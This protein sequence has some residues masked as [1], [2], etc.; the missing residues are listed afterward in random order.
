MEIPVP[1]KQ[2]SFFVDL[3]KCVGCK[4]CVVA[5]K[6][7]NNTPWRDTWRK[8]DEIKEGSYPD[9]KATFVSLSCNHC[10]QP[11]CLKSCP[12]DAKIKRKE[13]GIVLIDQEKCIGCKRC[14]AA[15]PYGAPQFNENSQKVEKCTFCFH[16]LEAGLEP[17]CVTTCIGG[18]LHFG[19]LDKIEKLPDI[20]DQAPTMADPRLTNQTTR[21]RR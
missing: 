9:I 13:D 7:E 12:V 21:F 4:A 6:S 18:A 11:A 2:Q 3:R 5:C 20:V 16:R 19:W 1:D 17:A 8:V 14:V 10:E 15:C